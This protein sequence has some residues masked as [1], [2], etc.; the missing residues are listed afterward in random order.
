MC[1]QTGIFTVAKFLLKELEKR[2]LYILDPSSL[3]FDLAAT[4]I[5]SIGSYLL[6]LKRTLPKPF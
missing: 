5:Q 3:T 6:Q 1:T 2:F 4:L